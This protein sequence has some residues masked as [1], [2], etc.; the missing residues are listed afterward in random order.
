MHIW[1]FDAVCHLDEQNRFTH[2]FVPEQWPPKADEHPEF[3]RVGM[4]AHLV[5]TGL[6]VQYLVCHVIHMVSCPYLGKN[7]NCI[8]L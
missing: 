7:P 5:R 8:Y 3:L 4:C 1:L 6:M 2:S